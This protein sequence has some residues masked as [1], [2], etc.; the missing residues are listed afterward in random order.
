[1]TEHK[2][3]TSTN[4]AAMLAYL[5]APRIGHAGG[6]IATDRKLRLFSCACLDLVNGHHREEYEHRTPFR[7]D[8]AAEWARSNA[9]LEEDAHP[10]SVMGRSLIKNLNAKHAALLR[11]IFGNPFR[12]VNCGWKTVQAAQH[13]SPAALESGASEEQQWFGDWLPS[14]D[15]LAVATSIYAE[16]R[17]Q[18]MPILADAL[19]EAGCD[20]EDML[21]H[22]RGLERCWVC[23]GKDCKWHVAPF[24]M[25]IESTHCR[26][27]WQHLR[28][29]HC[30]GCWVVDLI[31][32][33]G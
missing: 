16:N 25:S 12:P 30:R 15:V 26:G 9:R 31:L 21:Q 23:N 17:W 33:K 22:C 32:E 6:R 5:H 11:E 20:N 3:L 18:D 1:M 24:G 4:P 8:D 28:G 14:G 2:W 29:P 7:S 13:M 10:E 27:G 19:E